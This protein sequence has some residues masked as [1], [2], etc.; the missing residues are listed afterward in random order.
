MPSAPCSAWLSL[1]DF[2]FQFVIPIINQYRCV[3]DFNVRLMRDA[4]LKYRA[5]LVDDDAL[6]VGILK[7][8]LPLIALHET[9]AVIIKIRNPRNLL[10][11][12]AAPKECLNL[13]IVMRIPQVLEKAGHAAEYAAKGYSDGYPSSLGF[14]EWLHSL[15]GLA[16]RLGT[17]D[18]ERE[19]SKTGQMPFGLLPAPVLLDLRGSFVDI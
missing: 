12:N 11:C 10:P 3:L 6:A 8:D 19:A 1:V 7:K 9:N 13:T 16:E 18:G 2:E 5:V 15:Y 14:R 4:L 17:G